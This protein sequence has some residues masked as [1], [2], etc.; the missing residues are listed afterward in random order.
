MVEK[1]T[2]CVFEWVAS[3][4]Q[5]IPFD[6]LFVDVNLFEVSEEKASQM[7]EDKSL[8]INHGE[9]SFGARMFE[10]DDLADEAENL[11]IKLKFFTY[12]LTTFLIHN[13]ISTLLKN[14]PAAY[15][16]YYLRKMK[17]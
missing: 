2:I 7:F 12:K 4:S 17:I 15:K 13:G 3:N 5:W 8:L 6:A 10:H 11:M 1:F 9:S 14:G 16:E